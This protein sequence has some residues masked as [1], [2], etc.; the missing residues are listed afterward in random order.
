MQNETKKDR[1]PVWRDGLAD[2]ENSLTEKIRARRKEEETKE[3]E[4]VLIQDLEEDL[5]DSEQKE[6]EYGGFECE[7]FPDLKIV[8]PRY[9]LLMSFL[10]P[11]I[12]MILIF[13]QRGIFPF[14][15][16][17]FLRTDMYHQYAPFFS[18][19]RYKLTHGGSLLYSWDVGMGINFA[20][21]YAYYLASPLNWLI[22]L[23]PA[24]YVIEFMTVSIVIKIGLCGWSMAYYLRHH[25]HTEDFGIVFFGVFYAL[26]GYMAA[27]SWNIMWLD[28]IVVFPLI[29]LALERLVRE[30]KGMAYCLLL[31]FSILSNYYI[32]I[33]TCMFLVIYMIALLILEQQMTLEKFVGRV[34]KFCGYSLLAGGL[35]A[36]VLLPEIYALQSTAS[37]SS[38]FPQTITQYFSIFDMLARHIGNVETEIGLDHWPNIYCGV[39]VIMFFF[40]YLGCRQ[41]RPKEKV[42]SCV[43]LLFFM[44]SFSINVLNYIWHGFHYPNSLP[45][46]Q[47]YIYIWLVLLVCYEAYIHLSEIPWSQVARAFGFSAAFVLMAQKLLEENEQFHFAVF[48]AAILFL[49]LYLAGIAWYRKKPR[50]RCI[51]LFYTLAVVTIEAAVNTAVTS[52]TTTSR[53]EYTKDNHAVENMVSTVQ[54][55]KTFFRIKKEKGKTKNDGAWMHFPSVSLFSSTAS[56]DLS[57]LFKKLGCESSTNAYSI[58]G[59]TPLID[60]LFSVKYGFYPEEQQKTG[61]QTFL[62]QENETWFYENNYTLPLG[63]FV[64]SD[65][66]YRWDLDSGKPADVQ[67]S[68]ADALDADQ[69]LEMVMDTQSDGIS[70][71]FT[72]AESGRYYAYVRNK[73]IEKVTADTWNGSK[74]FTNTDRGYLLDLGWCAAGNEVT[75]T[76]E[77]TSEVLDANVY[78]FSDQ[79]LISVYDKL[80][81]QPWIL[82]SWTDSSLEGTISCKDSGTMMTT[83]PY[84]KGWKILVDGEE[85]T[86]EKVLDAFIGISLTPGEHTISMKYF[87]EGLK[88]GAW[89]TVGSIV[90][91]LLIFGSSRLL[92]KAR[93]YEQEQNEER[94]DPENEDHGNECDGKEHDES[95]D[96]E[97]QHDESEYR[98]SEN[99][100]NEDHENDQ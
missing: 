99:H 48:Y 78:R 32:S 35:S 29:M 18:E 2:Q 9:A 84:D 51:I 13:V 10:I 55:N 45:C 61:L 91:V 66:F 46:R 72:P 52:V 30:G 95:V 44:A 73:K 54:P 16:E 7:V 49:A 65:F 12:V 94:E 56:A 58:V 71:S 14:G 93:L 62:A 22:L 86:A 63:F 88:M 81:A 36:V 97:S 4:K 87:P 80:S 31:G 47:S 98:G 15:E 25:C 64:A 74:T 41:I 57:K 24:K 92:R 38:T 11:V 76:A 3:T 23:C 27:Y 75:L 19:F 42:V 70:M 96:D 83:I 50:W 59:S 20:A 43:M 82:T 8:S 53:T 17:S 34:F 100:Q 40:L 5:E 21:L 79:G 67:N 85:Q 89:I 28:C 60:S 90:I 68:L 39:A 33:M 37:G 77:E 26:S 69:V 6:T 1:H